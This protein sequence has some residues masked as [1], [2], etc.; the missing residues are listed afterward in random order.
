M[1]PGVRTG[2]SK[3]AGG[4]VLSNDSAMT[5]GRQ[6]LLTSMWGGRKQAVAI[7]TMP[8]GDPPSLMLWGEEDLGDRRYSRRS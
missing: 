1:V 8:N 3:A 4:P 2:G 5:A 6:N 7:C